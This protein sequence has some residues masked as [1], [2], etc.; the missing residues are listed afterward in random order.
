[1]E[2]KAYVFIDGD[3]TSYNELHGLNQLPEFCVVFIYYDQ[4]HSKMFD[5]NNM[6]KITKDMVANLNKIIVEEAKNSVDFRIVSDASIILQS[7]DVD[8][9]YIVSSDKGY[10]SV[11]GYLKRTY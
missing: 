2:H 11:L 5:S 3:N 7:K 8:Y 6:K 1:M 10:D 4:K 9:I